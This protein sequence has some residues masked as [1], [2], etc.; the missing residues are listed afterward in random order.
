[1]SW[2]SNKKENT[3]TT[4]PE[5]PDFQDSP[6]STNKILM[7]EGYSEQEIV[8]LT[9]IETSPLPPLPNFQNQEQIKPAIQKQNNQEMQISNFAPLPQLNDY[10]KTPVKPVIL[11][12]IT[13]RIQPPEKLNQEQSY[14]SS[15]KKTEP[16][17]IKLDK[18]ETTVQTFEEIK[19]KIGEIE[20]LLVKTKEIKAEEEKELEEWEKEIHIIKSRL[21]SIDKTVF[22]DIN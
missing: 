22:K 4:L 18:F 20:K 2:F 8:P 13:P 14:K 6:E 17:Y 15:S 10:E 3:K 19:D 5:L 7:Q 9:N 21:D 16:I 12:P 11:S 1:M